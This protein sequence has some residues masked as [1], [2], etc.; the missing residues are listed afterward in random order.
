[1]ATPSNK[2]LSSIHPTLQLFSSSIFYPCSFSSFFY[3]PFCPSH[4]FFSSF[5]IFSP[6]FL[7]PPRMVHF[8]NY[9]SKYHFL[10]L[11]TSSI[12]KKINFAKYI[13]KNIYHQKTDLSKNGV[14][15]S[16]TKNRTATTSLP[17]FVSSVSSYILIGVVLLVG[18]YLQ[19]AKRYT[20]IIKMT[21]K[22]KN[23]III[24]WL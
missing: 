13:A 16:R 10:N 22:G 3:I 9:P 11:L 14:S 19:Y 18:F 24:V 20:Y 1:M 2:L 6:S 15:I 23:V 5:S 21:Y 8:T 7:H 4:Q 17:S 12:S